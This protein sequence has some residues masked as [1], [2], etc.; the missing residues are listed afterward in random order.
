MSKAELR[1][2]TGISPNTMTKLN[3]DEKVSL[4]VLIKICEIL[5]T[6]VGNIVEYVSEYKE[7]FNE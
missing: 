5:N 6:D 3:R 2:A 4:N 1:K 7:T